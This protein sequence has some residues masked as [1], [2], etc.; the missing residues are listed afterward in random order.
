MQSENPDPVHRT[1]MQGTVS[2]PLEFKPM[3]GYRTYLREKYGFSEQEAEGIL[4]ATH[5]TVSLV[6][7]RLGSLE[8]HLDGRFD[9][10]SKAIREVKRNQWIHTI[11]VTVTV[12]A[13]ALVPFIA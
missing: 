3:M 10:V 11:T 7:E 4:M 1:H 8:T 13:A 2:Y 9:D 6:I 12:V 5:D